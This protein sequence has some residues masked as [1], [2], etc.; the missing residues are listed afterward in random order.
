MTVM[1]AGDQG[2]KVETIVTIVDHLEGARK[3]LKKEGLEL[4]SLFTGEDFRQ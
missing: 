3:N 2:S 1:K 4:V